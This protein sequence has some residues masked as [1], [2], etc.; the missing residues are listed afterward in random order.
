MYIASVYSLSGREQKTFLAAWNRIS[1]SGRLVSFL[2]RHRRM[3]EAKEV[4]RKREG[5]SGTA[6]SGRLVRKAEQQSKKPIL[7][8][9][10][11]SLSFSV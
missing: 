5:R 8:I 9:L 1:R 10:S 3:T 6:G 4:P 11:L 7:V 2:Y